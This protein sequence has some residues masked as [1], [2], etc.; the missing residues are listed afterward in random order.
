[1]AT[2]YSDFV[3]EVQHRIKADTQAEAVRTTRAVL[4]TLGER[5]DEGGATDVASPLPMEID[6]Y[7]LAVEH[8]HTYDFDEFV[9]RVETK[10]NDDDLDFEASYGT[11]ADV[12]PADAVYR[13]KAVVALTSEL[14]PGGELAHVE[15]QLPDEFEELFEFVDAETKPWEQEA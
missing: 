13:A 9:D 6:R 10:L 12:E 15:R 3:G 5:V 14:V 2:S 4:E 11:P 1:M 7:L 8:G